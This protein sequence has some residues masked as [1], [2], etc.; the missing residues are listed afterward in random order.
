MRT[1]LCLSVVT[2]L[3]AD[4]VSGQ[5]PLPTPAACTAFVSA[6]NTGSRDPLQWPQVSACGTAGANALASALNNARTEIDTLYLSALL[7]E[8]SSIRDNGVL[9]TA[10]SVGGDP[11][12]T[13][14]ARITA[15]LAAMAQINNSD[16]M[17]VGKSYGDVLG[18]TTEKNC[19]WQPG[20]TGSLYKSTGAVLVEPAQ[21]LGRTLDSVYY[22][23]SPL[24]IRS[25]ARCLRVRIPYGALPTVPASAIAITYVCGNRFKYKNN[26][27]ESVTLTYRVDTIGV[28]DQGDVTVPA[29]QER[30]VTTRAAGPVDTYF[31]QGARFDQ[32]KKNLGTICP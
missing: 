32:K 14:V 12:A 27:L 17:K 13:V 23:T 25:F 6:L 30:T 24:V 3:A 31:F 20:G 21:R 16:G 18:N 8:L 19:Y 15:L 22:S 4:A 5:M 29:G 11:T 1:F 7:V 9:T 28:S 2:A 26:G 10:R